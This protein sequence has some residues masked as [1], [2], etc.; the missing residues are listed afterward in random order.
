MVGS[1]G[2]GLSSMNRFISVVAGSVVPLT[3]SWSSQSV[4]SAGSVIVGGQ[5]KV[6]LTDTTS[7]RSVSS[8][9]I[10]AMTLKVWTPLPNGGSVCRISVIDHAVGYPSEQEE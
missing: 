9:S 6:I 1:V 4:M 8:S 3:V 7:D 2:W 5:F 10:I